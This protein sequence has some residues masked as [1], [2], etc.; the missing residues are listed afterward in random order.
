MTRII[1]RKA[2]IIII[3]IIILIILLLVIILGILKIQVVADNLYTICKYI[4]AWY[5]FIYSIL[6]Y[7]CSGYC[8][9]KIKNINQKIYLFTS[10][11]CS[12]FEKW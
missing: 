10:G 11:V 6:L 3:I 1:I 2:I 4:N 8:L 7:V 12:P 9:I 5:V